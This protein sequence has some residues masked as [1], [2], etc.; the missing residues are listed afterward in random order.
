MNIG[1]L[2]LGILIVIGFLYLIYGKNPPND[3][4]YD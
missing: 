1:G 4:S 3:N 2:I